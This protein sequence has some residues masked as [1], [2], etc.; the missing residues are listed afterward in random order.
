V[1]GLPD[2]PGL[3]PAAE[4]VEAISHPAIMDASK[5]KSEL[6]W[7]PKYTSAEALQDT[8]K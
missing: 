8:L 3:P 6:G 1:A 4:W 7:T 5:A 2:I